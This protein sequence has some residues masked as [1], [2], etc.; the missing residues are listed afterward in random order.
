MKRSKTVLLECTVGVSMGRVEPIV[1][2]NVECATAD[3]FSVPA[4]RGI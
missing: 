1:L 4:R 3:G 2:D